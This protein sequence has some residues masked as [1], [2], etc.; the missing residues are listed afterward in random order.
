MNKVY[1]HKSLAPDEYLGWVD[2]TGRV[3]ESRFGPDKLIGRVNIADGKIF[4]SR[5]G[6]DRQIG[7]VDLKNGKVYLS[8]LG[9]DEYLGAVHGDGKLYAHVSLGGD[10]YLGKVADMVSYA[11][12]GAA[13]LL[14]IQPAYDEEEVEAAKRAGAIDP[15]E[16]EAGAAP[17]PA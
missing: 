15:G 13:F 2:E 8:K 10:D 3:Y 11:H 14:L 4:E 7:Q 6:P 12:G 1:K 5:L 9:P 17:A 16:A